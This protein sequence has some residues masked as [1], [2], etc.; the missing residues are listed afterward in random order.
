MLAFCFHLDPG[1]EFWW[2]FFVKNCDD[3]KRPL[4]TNPFSPLPIPMPRSLSRQKTI[5]ASV[6]VLW[7]AGVA[8]G[9]A[10]LL[11]YAATPGTSQPSPLS[12]P[13]ESSLER[14]T[15]RPNLVMFVHPRC[16]CTR[17]SMSEWERLL[18]RCQGALT[19][20]VL[21]YRPCS[22]PEDWGETDL[23]QR[24]AVIPGVHVRQDEDGIEARRFQANTSGEVLL[25]GA[26][27][28]L[29]F[30]GGITNARGHA[31][32]SA[33]LDAILSRLNDGTEPLAQTPV[34]GCPLFAPCSP[35]TAGDSP[36]RP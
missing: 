24:A 14:D 3:G 4:D 7:A 18:A 17:A 21:F 8:A 20:H 13:D 11:Q 31:G 23:W 35:P 34:F 10:Q 9:F 16:S 5:L 25:Y 15:T 29:L 32:D 26:D 2:T 22:L 33:G 27:G 30:Q 1:L 36:C 28:S 6:T 19:A 12:W